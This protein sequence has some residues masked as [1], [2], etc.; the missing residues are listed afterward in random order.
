MGT[1]REAEP[2]EAAQPAKNQQEPT[3][4]RQ[5][6]EDQP[7]PTESQQPIER[8]SPWFGRRLVYLALIAAALLTAIRGYGAI[9]AR[10]EP[11][12][13]HELH[14]MAGTKAT[15]GQASLFRALIHSGR[16]GQPLSD[17]N[18]R[19]RLVDAHGEVV[20]EQE[21]ETDERG[22]ATVR[23]RLPE[24]LSEGSY[25]LQVRAEGH[26]PDLETSQQIEIG[27]SFR[28]FLTTDKPRYQP[29]Q[30]IHI[31]SLALFDL[32]R[33][34]VAGREA[35]IDVRDARGNK[36]FNRELETSEFGL[37]AA[38]FQ[39]ADEVNMGTF[40]VR[41]TLGHTST[42]RTVTVERY[43]LPRFRVELETDRGFFAPAEVV[44]GAVSAR[45]TFGEPV[46][47]AEVSLVASRAPGDQEPFQTITGRTDDQG[48]LAF[49]LT[50]PR[51]DGEP[52][53]QEE[54]PPITL[55]ATVTDGA[56]RS[57]ERGLELLVTGQPIRVDIVPESGE[58]V[59]GVENQVYL[60]TSYPDGSPA[61]TTLAIDVAGEEPESETLRTGEAGFAQWSWTPDTSEAQQVTV[62]AEDGQGRQG[63]ASL[64]HRPSGQARQS[65]L[66]RPDRPIYRAGETARLTVLT[67][68]D[69]PRAFL[70]VVK[71]GQIVATRTAELRGGRGEVTLELPE[72][73]TGTLAITASYLSPGSGLASDTRA[74]QVAEAA[75]LDITAELDQETYR[76]GE[77]ATLSLRVLRGQEPAPAALSL[78]GVDEAVFALQEARPGL[79]RVFFAL[80]GSLAESSAASVLATPP[81]DVGQNRAAA[82]ALAAVE[83]IEGS[84]HTRGETYERRL[85]LQERRVRRAT[86]SLWWVPVLAPAFLFLVLVLPILG[87]GLGRLFRRRPVRGAG[88]DELSL[89][90]GLFRRLILFWVLGFS[91]PVLALALLAALVP[92]SYQHGGGLAASAVAALWITFTLLLSV[93]ALKI[94]RSSL[95]RAFPGLRRLVAFVPYAYLCSFPAALIAILV[96]DET[97]VL[98]DSVA[99][100]TL[101]VVLAG[102]TL[103]TGALA[104]S[105]ASVLRDISTARA[106]W[107]GLSR[108]FVASLPLL[109]ILALF[110]VTLSAPLGG[111]IAGEETGL[112]PPAGLARQDSAVRSRAESGRGGGLKAPSRVRRHFPETLLWRPEVITNEEGRAEVE[113]PLADSITTWRVGVGAVTT[114]GSLG[115]KTL[116]LRVFQP[117]FVEP[118]LPVALT[119]NDAVQLRVAVYNYLEKSQTVRLELSAGDWL[120][121]R[122]GRSQSL[123]LAPREVT[124]V[125]FPVVAKRPG[126]HRLQVQAYGSEM[127]DAIER[128]ARVSPDG[129]RVDELINGRLGEGAELEITLPDNA[130]EGA[131]ALV[132]KVY[133]GAF[134]QVV[135]GLEGILRRP[136]GCF[137]QTS[138]ATYPNVLVLDYLRRNHLARPEI[139]ERARSYIN[140]GYQR[141]LSFEVE[142]GGFEWFGRPPAH[143]VLTAYGLME[144]TDMAEVFEIDPA[145]I[146]RTRR[147]LLEQQESDGSFQPTSGGIAEGAI[148]AYQG[149]TLRTTAYIAWA[150]AE[151][152][153]D[154]TRLGTAI[155]YIELH[156]SETD[157]P[158]TLALAANALLATGREAGAA[159]RRLDSMKRREGDLV[160]WPSTGEGVTHSRGETLDMETTALVAYAFLRARHDPSAAQAA[161]A[162]LVSNKDAFG[163][164]SSTQATIHAMRALLL[165]S[166]EPI[167]APVRIDVEVNGETAGELV[168]SPE[169]AD[170][171]HTVV[172]SDH[173]RP[174]TNRVRLRAER[175]NELAYQLLATH[176]LPWPEGRA[177]GDEPLTLEVGYDATTLA[178]GGELTAR[179]TIRYDRPEP[180]QLAIVELGLPPGFEPETETFDSLQHDR[181]IQRYALAAGRAT[182]YFGELVRDEP[183]SFEYRLR[184]QYPAR[185]TAPPSSVYLYYEPEVRD[186]T[187]PVVLTVR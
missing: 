147:W 27:R 164:W 70:D 172:L 98:P 67:A 45:Y 140:T 12:A 91:A 88:E 145:V 167:E 5:P 11:V 31:R 136:T 134:S 177:A 94:R 131:N 18:T 66:L 179:V 135:E 160:Y 125:S 124:Q 102:A 44:R 86:R 159:L 170:V 32:D 48:R 163:T 126:E 59:A 108:I 154:G 111:V 4:G 34:P 150:L 110:M 183:V 143:N 105:G 161:L 139:E 37:A 3:E 83:E 21:E 113:V 184:A 54:Q 68:G 52:P 114:G 51:G 149:Q 96:A 53:R 14:L 84:S 117:F 148:N 62:A 85:A 65:L 87:Y 63:S 133:P 138:S 79:E 26:G 180:G 73:L 33:R 112:P 106:V 46:A 186:E 19:F 115:S 122:G 132:L 8:P 61:Q 43:V 151:A 23:P 16:T 176:Y 17:V 56:G 2:T 72:E 174:G 142:G 47:R 166:G 29:G 42:E 144:L 162:W 153:E 109:L 168:V 157:D 182:L 13:E 97:S 6:A 75:E 185:V 173:F 89:M 169:T 41:A 55:T 156:V 69:A 28:I 181:V 64:S 158:Y 39:L 1:S 15:P 119:Q 121:V 93:T 130:I 137:E 25:R 80:Q 171:F 146:Q 57:E 82:V 123:K 116:G 100:M 77:V 76:P 127:A 99:A 49:E 165:G 141:L 129:E 38:D 71:Q 10:N 90:R 152:G 78:W 36:V 22:I 81:E 101:L 92:Y 187:E 35:T 9:A 175:T 40:T 95:S 24:D 74:V 60:V 20:W 7:E 178:A 118:D 104:L 120:E 155:E 107:I 30:I 103:A 50:L 58:P 128:R